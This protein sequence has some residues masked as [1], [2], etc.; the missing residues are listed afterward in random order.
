MTFILFFS[1]SS[2]AY[3]PI[4]NKY[5][6]SLNRPAHLYV[7][8]SSSMN[9][10]QKIM[11]LTLQGIVAQNK[12]EIYVDFGDSSTTWLD[13]LKNNYSISYER[14][15]DPWWY[16]DHFKSTLDGYILFNMGDNSENAATTLAGLFRAVAVDSSL[17]A[18]A[19]SHGL[20]RKIDARGKDEIWVFNN[21]WSEL[22]HNLLFELNESIHDCLR[23][24]S[25]AT[26]SFLFYDG[27]SSHRLDWVAAAD[28][29]SPI[30]GWGD[31]TY[32]E[33]KFVKPSAERSIFTVAADYAKNLSVLSAISDN[34]TQG[35]HSTP[36]FE[37]NVHYVTFVMSDGDNVQWLLNTFLTDAK[38]YGSPRRGEFNVGWTISPSLVDLAPSVMRY[39]YRNA[40]N[41]DKKD[42]FIAGVSGAGYMYPDYYPALDIF[43][44]RLE[45][46]LERADLDI[47]NVMPYDINGFKT[48]N[49]DKYTRLARVIGCLSINYFKYDYDKG[50]ML[51]SNGKPVVA[52]REFMNSFAPG[53]TPLD[54]ASRINALP[55]DPTKIDSYSYVIV[56]CWSYGLDD[57]AT[58]IQN[59][60]AD[61]RVVPPDAF[62]KLIRSH[63][64]KAPP[65]GGIIIN[66]GA[67]QTNNPQVSL[68]ITATDNESG[69][70]EMM[71]SN[72]SNFNGA[73]WESFSQS[74]VWNLNSSPGT[75]TVYVKFR[76]YA[77]NESP[78]YNDNIILDTQ[79][80]TGT[81]LINGGDGLTHSN[82]V[83]LTF[84]ATDNV[85]VNSMI[86]SN[87]ANF[88][89]AN[90]ENYATPK[91]W[92]L[93]AID[94]EK[95]VFVKFKDGVGNPS[96]I[97]SDSINL[98]TTRKVKR[99]A[100]NDRYLTA[101]EICKEGWSSA[102][103]VVLARGDL[104][105]DVLAGATLAKA[106][107]APILL[108]TS[109]SL[110]SP[111][112]DEIKSLGAKKAYILGGEDAIS[113]RVVDD[114][115]SKNSIADNDIKRLGG[116]NRYETAALIGGELSS[117]V[118]K[119]AIIATGE[120]YPDALASAS[121]AAYLGMPIVLV[122][123]DSVS[124]KEEEL[125]N[126]LKIN[127]TIIVGGTSV[128]SSSVESWL[129]SHNYNPMRLAGDDRYNTARAIID[130]ALINGFKVDYLSV[131]TGENFPDALASGPMA[132]MLKAPIILVRKAFIPD[133]IKGLLTNNKDK[134]YIVYISG[135]EAA[136]SEDI[137]TNIAE[138]IG[139]Q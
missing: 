51:W 56:H 34:A 72:N 32:G 78:I 134:I 109:S 110:Y 19:I 24:Y 48:E 1:L 88:S 111:T 75:K 29:D 18:E 129:T 122:E 64:D 100:G 135:G 47:V 16:I 4:N 50:K 57:I 99:L 71:I 59:L 126:N 35:T 58:C 40:A 66:N 91:A 101:I 120:N 125:M 93:T 115:K 26:K 123:K 60:D 20:S 137:K 74:K 113:A 117:P 63:V 104:F 131:V 52:A 36:N 68:S 17:E 112:S 102:Q 67:S 119:T 65:T 61:V 77:C 2:K 82:L 41:G 76:D 139:L 85:G 73:N 116:A 114:L 9:D 45:N 37:N 130:Y 107:N 105:P 106:K 133:K 62:L 23:D 5:Y 7:I 84:S 90:W 118:N 127:K 95:T 132:A 80:P 96:N 121:L 30:L 136:V 138:I 27:N 55:T 8:K 38:W 6:P 94:G 108:T 83:T 11:I 31:P 25:A 49:F 128:V 98:I 43:T 89:G 10:A 42:Y 14:N 92:N 39:L 3:E 46:Y 15:E 81:V 103:A 44:T 79:A 13:D 86:I 21:Y 22:R 87:N 124:S 54:I 53:S 33:D 12:P 69:L 70:T 28:D 97:A